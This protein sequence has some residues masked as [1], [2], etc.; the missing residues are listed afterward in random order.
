MMTVME[1]VPLQCLC[2]C[3]ALCLERPH[4]TPCLPLFSLQTAIT[5][6]DITRVDCHLPRQLPALQAQSP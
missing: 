2:L 6:R 3:C 4:P 1:R 5:C